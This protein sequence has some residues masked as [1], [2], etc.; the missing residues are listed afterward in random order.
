MTLN[1]SPTNYRPMRQ[2]QLMRWTGKTWE[3]FG[4]LIEGSELT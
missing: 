1:T 3:R 2:L 4:G